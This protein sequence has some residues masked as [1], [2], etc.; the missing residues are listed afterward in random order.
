M[1]N[2]EN[3]GMKALWDYVNRLGRPDK[4]PWVGLTEKEKERLWEK[5]GDTFLIEKVEA[6]LK[7]RNT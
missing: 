5:G 3:K 7:E 4:R 2:D 6:L 1:S